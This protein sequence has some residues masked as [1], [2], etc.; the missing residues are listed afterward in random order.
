MLRS[1]LG[2][3]LITRKQNIFSK[4]KEKEIMNF[5]SNVVD[6]AEGLRTNEET[7]TTN[8]E[9]N[10]INMGNNNMVKLSK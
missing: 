6:G 1:A 9:S 5:Q 8:N 4:S 2:K 3:E 10:D 7:T